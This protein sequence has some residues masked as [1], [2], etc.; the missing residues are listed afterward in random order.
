MRLIQSK[1]K[2]LR[3]FLGFALIVCV[4]GLPSYSFAVKEPTSKLTV[5][6]V[7]YPLKYFAERIAGEHA[8]VVFPVPGNVDPA[9]WMPDAETIQQYQ[10]LIY[11]WL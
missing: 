3:C 4:L 10:R 11:Y 6:V 9:F 8:R 7:N 2:A 5:Y 1:K